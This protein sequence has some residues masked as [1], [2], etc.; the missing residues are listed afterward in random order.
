M[1]KFS[2]ISLDRLHTCDERLQAIC[3]EVIK[4]FDF[5]VV[6]GRRDKEDQDAAY[7]SGKSKLKWPESKHNRM[8]SLAVDIAPY[9]NGG[10]AWS[11]TRSF[12]YL[13]GLMK[14]IAAQKGITLRWGGDWN[15]DNDFSDQSFNDFPHFEIVG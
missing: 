4:H 3:E 10:I 14:G 6:C 8:P 11:D 13:A 2:K 7:N 5:T 12:Y 15:S 9:R 1:P